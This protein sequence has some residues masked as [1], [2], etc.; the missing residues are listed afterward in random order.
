M[1][2]EKWYLE[3]TNN[4]NQLLRVRDDID[5]PQVFKK[6]ENLV[7]LKHNF[8]VADDIMFPD[9]SC[10]AFF[11]AFENNHLEA[12]EEENKM[13]L[14]AVDICEGLMKFYIYCSDTNQTINDCIL[15]LKSNSLY[16]CDFEVYLNDRGERL[17]KLI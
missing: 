6:F 2:E 14:L 4:L 3:N 13:A 1:D 17:N 9:P 16:K 7:I 11:M 8:H 15:F 5:L 12:L 10:L